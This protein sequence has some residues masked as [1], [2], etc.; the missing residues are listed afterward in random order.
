P[1]AA[2]VASALE[3]SVEPSFENRRALIG[4]EESRGEHEYV[5]VVVLPRQLGDLRIPRDRR[6]YT[7][8]SIRRVTH[9][10]SGAAKENASVRF[11]LRHLPGERMRIVGV[12]RRLRA[13]HAEVV[14]VE[15]EVGESVLESFLERE[16]GVVGGNQ[17]SFGH[18]GLGRWRAGRPT[19][20]VR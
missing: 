7:R 11:S 1:N 10:E 17:N 14:D 19:S 2:R 9:A 6:A 5:R 12:V 20:F 8:V 15:A 4:A 16:A 18:W 13:I 3:R